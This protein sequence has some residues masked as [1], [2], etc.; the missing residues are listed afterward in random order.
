MPGGKFWW[1][2]VEGYLMFSVELS[3]RAKAPAD[4]ALGI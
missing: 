2:L 4:E 3:D 1:R